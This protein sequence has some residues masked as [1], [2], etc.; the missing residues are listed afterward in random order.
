MRN[1]VDNAAGMFDSVR[2]FTYTVLIS[3]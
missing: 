1:S 2:L 3:T